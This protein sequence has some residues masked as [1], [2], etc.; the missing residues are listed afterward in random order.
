MLLAVGQRYSGTVESLCLGL[1]DLGVLEQCLSAEW[2]CR[3]LAS[4]CLHAADG[5]ERGPTNLS[6][7]GG[8]VHL[9]PQS[10]QSET[11]RIWRA[12]HADPAVFIALKMG[13]ELKQNEE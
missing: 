4:F 12:E 2:W 7:K 11:W 1:L 13:E 9:F 3:V 5:R 10:L 8:K 6:W